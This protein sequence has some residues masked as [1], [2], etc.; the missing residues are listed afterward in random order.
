[1]NTCKSV[2]RY[3]PKLE[4]D[5]GQT[6]ACCKADPVPFG[7]G[8]FVHDGPCCSDPLC[9]DCDQRLVEVRVVAERKALRDA[10]WKA[11]STVDMGG[12]ITTEHVNALRE[13]VVMADGR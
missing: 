6:G 4:I 9:G 3:G 7:Y 2:D 8:E 1:M 13:A 10:A 11:C 5:R 12:T